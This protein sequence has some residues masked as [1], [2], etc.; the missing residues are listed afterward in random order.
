MNSKIIV[1]GNIISELSEK[2]PSNL[3]ALNELIKNAYDAGAKKVSI[4]LDSSKKTLTIADNGS[5]MDKNDI[6]TLFHI[7][8]S[9]KIYGKMNKYKRYTQGSKGLG[10]LSVFKFGKN[11]EWITRKQAGLKFSIDFDEIVK[12]TDIGEY[13]V[14]IIPFPTKSKGTQITIALDSYNA[15]ALYNF[16]S[17]EKNYKKILNS[18][19]DDHF[20][21]E[22]IIDG[23]Q[24]LCG[25]STDKDEN[26]KER[27]LYKV[28]YSSKSEK[29]V[30]SHRGQKIK[31]ISFPLNPSSYSLEADITIFQLPTHGKGNID[32]LFLN[33]QDDLTPLIYV[34]SNLFNNYSLFNPNLMRNVKSGLSLSQMIGFIR[35]FSSDQ[36]INFNSDRTQFV[37]NQLTDSII[38]ALE[39]LN[40]TIQVSG[41]EYKRYLIDLDFLST[42]EINKNDF[43]EITTAIARKFIKRDFYFKDKVVISIAENKVSYE[44]FG[45][46][47]ILPI[48]EKESQISSD[49]DTILPTIQRAILEIKQ[50]PD[51]FTVPTD[52]IDLKK[53]I[54][55]AIDSYGKSIPTSEIEIL[56]S[57]EQIA[58]GILASVTSPC[59]KNFEFRYVDPQTKLVAT[60]LA[61]SFEMP[62]ANIITGDKEGKLINFPG[63][64]NYKINFDENVNRL[65][66]QIN[67][68]DIDFYMEVISCS[69]RTILE[70]STDSI[71]TSSKASKII[72]VTDSLEEKI[73]AIV[74]FASGKPILSQIATSS[75]ISFTTLKNK[76][77]S[78]EFGKAVSLAHLC[79]HKAGTYVTKED[80]VSLAKQIGIFIVITNEL[81]GNTK[82]KI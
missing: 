18:F 4:L 1:G 51:R 44:V 45:Q 61:L 2:I 39:D 24:F 31:T 25:K 47:R 35:I 22:L 10:F 70:L 41:S 69:L 33:D 63:H 42:T 8:T 26:Y 21:I 65:V 27:Q 11:V 5:G 50:T 78:S 20:T 52:Q 68:L 75:T 62:A 46:T 43:S 14:P 60:S 23:R 9:E 34:N 72:K 6:D 82:I 79:A 77:N 66:D 38:R 30:F 53:Y 37:Q 54:V 81:L 28:T 57:D 49:E 36:N 19:F 48:V 32:P 7:S 76:L 56:E 13:E 74:T 71:A 17:I 80:V 40:R 3:V 16:F 64:K 15:T 55:N 29:I 59:R 12:I 73:N 67:K 58:G